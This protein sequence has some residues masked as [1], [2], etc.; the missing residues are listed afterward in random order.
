MFLSFVRMFFDADFRK[1]NRTG[2]SNIFQLP[3]HKLY[4]V[5]YF[6]QYPSNSLK[7][8]PKSNQFG[9]DFFVRVCLNFLDFYFH[10][11]CSLMV[12]FVIK[13]PLLFAIFKKILLI[14]GSRGTLFSLLVCLFSSKSIEFDDETTSL[15]PESML[16]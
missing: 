5:I 15:L 4:Q 7:K 10:Q 13:I 2:F 12:I 9:F 1:Q 11:G 6:L 14:N 16:E 8:L 3:A